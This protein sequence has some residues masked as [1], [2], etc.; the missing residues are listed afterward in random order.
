MSRSGLRRPS[1]RPVVPELGGETTPPPSGDRVPVIVAAMVAITVAVGLTAKSFGV[2]WGAPAQPLLITLDPVLTGWLALSLGGLAA[3]LH[4][5]LRLFRSEAG[6]GRFGLALFGLALF[7]R[8]AL[9][10]ARSGPDEWYSVYIVRPVS[11]GRLEYLGA[12]TELRAG[13]GSFLDNFVA[14]VPTLPLH[15]AGHPPGL[16]VTL[17]LLGIETPEAMAALT[18]VVGAAATPVLYALGRQLF[19]E[20]TARVASLLF[21]FVPTALLY[22]AT[23]ADSLF[24]TLGLVAVLLMLSKRAVVVF[25]GTFFLAI[26]TFFSYALLAVAG[27]AG[28]VK[29]RR[30]GLLSMLRL[31]ALCVVVLVGFYAV[32]AWT[33]GFDV[34]GAIEATHDRYYKGVASIQPYLFYFFGSPA[35][36]L[37][38]LGPVAWFASRSLGS[39]EIT[40]LALAAVILVAVIGGYTKAETERIW[41]FLVPLACLSAARALP[42]RYL[43]PILV[44]LAAQAVLVE[45][46]FNT[47][48]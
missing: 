21:V 14:L 43:K 4:L 40:A 24:A 38:M 9:N 11:S 37:I 1:R 35:A 25:L 23:S 31:A 44:A 28:L 18:I 29:W 13:I 30:D 15:P 20:K 26:A 39:R 42:D 27:W 19:D 17:D 2:Y 22:G 16:V 41:L 32:L 34:T 7:T 8:L 45:V 47:T 5:A 48:W 6:P 12:M 36:F 10:L 46:V 3:G 33:T